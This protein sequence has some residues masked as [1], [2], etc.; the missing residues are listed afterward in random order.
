M[1][2][3]AAANVA[4][5]GVKFTRATAPVR[6]ITDAF[7]AD[8]CR[9]KKE[10]AVCDAAQANEGPPARQPDV[11]ELSY[12]L[13]CGTRFAP[14]D[15]RVTDP[16]NPVPVD[17]RV[18]RRF[19]LLVPSGAQAPGPVPPAAPPPFTADRFLCYKVRGPVFAVGASVSD[20]LYPDGYPRLALYRMTKL[21][22]PADSAGLD[23][24]A[25]SHPG[26]LTCY[27]ARLGAGLHFA[28]T[29]LSTRNDDVGAQVV[30]VSATTELCLPAT[31]VP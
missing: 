17:V 9:L 3:K 5:G 20:V 13:A 11:W 24:T 26:R 2:D 14:V 4:A 22:T 25:P 6:T 19:N 16:L 23:P 31:I 8:T 29:Y 18:L 15:V 7:G 1:C 21:C 30:Q 27:L 12:R 28:R 10:D